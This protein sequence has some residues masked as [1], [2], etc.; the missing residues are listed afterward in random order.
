MGFDAGIESSC[1]CDECNKTIHDGDKVVC[2]ECGTQEGQADSA[3]TGLREFIDREALSL[4][5]T[6][7]RVLHHVVEA[8]EDGLPLAF[9]RRSSRA[10]SA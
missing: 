3:A 2:R 5:V 10:V 1:T 8:M 6:E 7:T 4:T 9:V